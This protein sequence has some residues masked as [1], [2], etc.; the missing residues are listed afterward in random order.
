M[1]RAFEKC[2]DIKKQNRRTKEMWQMFISLYFIFVNSNTIQ[3][4]KQH[5]KLCER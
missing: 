2:C 4:L 3:F 5:L 1:M